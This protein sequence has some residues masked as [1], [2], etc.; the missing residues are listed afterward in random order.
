[1]TT[2]SRYLRAQNEADT[3]LELLREIVAPFEAESDDVLSM[4]HHQAV[5]IEFRTGELLM[6]AVIAARAII[7][8]ID[9]PDAAA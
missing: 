9:A 6:A 4:R 5:K 2:Q 1:M 7:A 3:M 8:R